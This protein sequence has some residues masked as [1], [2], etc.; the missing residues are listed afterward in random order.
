MW[1]VADLEPPPL[2]FATNVF[3]IIDGNK[4]P[5][6]APKMPLKDIS[7]PHA[8]PLLKILDG[9]IFSAALGAFKFFNLLILVGSRS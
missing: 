5:H 2:F 8:H 1:S 7:L 6:F 9:R 4:I 3:K